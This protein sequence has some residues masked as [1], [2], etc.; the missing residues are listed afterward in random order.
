MEFIWITLGAWTA[1]AAA[2]FVPGM[3]YGQIARG[4]DRSHA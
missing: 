2:A 3:V 1:F 4:C